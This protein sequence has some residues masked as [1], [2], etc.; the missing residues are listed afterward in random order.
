MAARAQLVFAAQLM[1]G[2]ALEAGGTTVRARPRRDAASGRAAGSAADAHG[3]AG[4]IA[5]VTVHVIL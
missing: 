4:D 2:Y 3:R 1:V 5:P